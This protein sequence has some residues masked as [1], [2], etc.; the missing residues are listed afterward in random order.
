MNGIWLVALPLLGAFLL[1]IAYRHLP[2]K[3]GNWTG[4]FILGMN[5]AIALG[6]WHEGPHS[7]AMG[8]FP[9]PLGIIFYVDH[10]ALLF[11]ITVVLGTLILWLGSSEMGGGWG[12]IREETLLLLLEA[13]GSGL[14]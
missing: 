3:V 10:L 4:P 7:I 12:R 2:T 14:A 11:V 1:P 6:L 8:G 9:A 5:L 13:G